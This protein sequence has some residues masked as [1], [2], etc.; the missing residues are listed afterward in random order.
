MI[1]GFIKEGG[2]FDVNYPLV[3]PALQEEYDL[4]VQSIKNHLT[5]YLEQKVPIPNWVYSY[6]I[7]SAI[8]VNSD[9]L[10]ILYL[11]SSFNLEDIDAVF[12]G[13]TSYN[14][15]QESKKWVEKLTVPY[16]ERPA[17]MFGEPHVVKSIRLRQVDVV[18]N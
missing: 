9:P 2:Y 1:E 6:M 11:R 5:A 12:D 17:T 13:E 16:E 8:S 18:G 3:A 14:C 7:G 10:D 15:Y 4:L